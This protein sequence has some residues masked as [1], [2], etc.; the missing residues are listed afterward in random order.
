MVPD[1]SVAR[2]DLLAKKKVDIHGW[3]PTLETKPL[4]IEAQISAKGSLFTGIAV[5]ASIEIFG[6]FTFHSLDAC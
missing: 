4:S 2:V 6:G 1:D 3:I 5:A